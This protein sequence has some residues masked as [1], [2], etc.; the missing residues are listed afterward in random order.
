MCIR[1]YSLTNLKYIYD[2]LKND[3]RYKHYFKMTTIRVCIAIY[4]TKIA[5]IIILSECLKYSIYLTFR[6]KIEGCC[7][8]TN[9]SSLLTHPP[10]LLQKKGLTRLYNWGVS[11]SLMYVYVTIAT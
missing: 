1:V 10:P 3:F 5:T 6:L 2:F 7:A 11:A 8:L 9:T 4:K